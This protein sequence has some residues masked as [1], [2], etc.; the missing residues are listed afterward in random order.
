MKLFFKKL[1]EG[2]PIIILHGLFG[3]SDNW[4]TISKK[5][6]DRY[7]IYL[8]DVRNHGQS[9]HSDDHSYQAMVGDL[10]EF[11]RDNNIEKPIIIGHSMG[12]KIAMNFAVD[13]PEVPEKIVVVDIAPKMYQ[14]EN[15]SNLEAM[16]AINLEE[17]KNLAD[18][19]GLWII[20]DACHAPGGFFTDSEGNEQ[21]CGNSK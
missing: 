9:P 2:K 8:L 10:S 6:A 7:S 4:L 19:Y 14:H 17:I 1:G 13:H 16:L 5:L 15:K 18:E 21:L 3:S 11:I 12:G 20:E